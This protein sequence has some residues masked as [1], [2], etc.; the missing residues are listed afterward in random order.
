MK[1]LVDENLPSSLSALIRSSGHHA[2]AVVETARRGLSDVDIW[3]WAARESAVLVTLDLDFPL[4]GRRPAPWAVI[5]LRSADQ[6]PETIRDLWL[7]S[8]ESFTLS[9][10]RGKVVSVRPNRVRA[11]ALP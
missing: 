2:V 11:R 4:P 1:F 3:D 7:K 9:R 5:L 6:K 10:I 8:R